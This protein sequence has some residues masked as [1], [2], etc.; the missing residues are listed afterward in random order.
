LRYSKLNKPNDYSYHIYK[1]NGVAYLVI[2][3]AEYPAKVAFMILNEMAR[4][5]M[6]EFNNVFI[7][8][9]NCKNMHNHRGL[10]NWIQKTRPL[11]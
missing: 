6:K 5:F 4:E 2:A 11:H 10:G 1:N 3:D 7:D 8:T 9:V